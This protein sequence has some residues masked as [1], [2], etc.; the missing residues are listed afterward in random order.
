[1]QL[2]LGLQAYLRRLGPGFTLRRHT[3][4]YQRF[5]DPVGFGD[6][7]LGNNK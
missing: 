3:R 1:M 4:E 2:P 7:A 5:A 6:D